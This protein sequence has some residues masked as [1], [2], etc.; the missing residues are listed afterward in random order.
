MKQTKI[1]EYTF[2]YI[3]DLYF[4]DLCK[5]LN[6]YTSN[7]EVIEDIVQDLFV[8]LWENREN[9]SIFHIKTYLFTSVRNKMLNLLRDS[10][11]FE[12][13]LEEH[14]IDLNQPD[15]EQSGFNEELY[16]LTRE[17]IDT[18]PLKCKELFLLSKKENK[19][20]KQIAEE[21]QIS[22]KTVENQMGIAYKKIREYVSEKVA[23]S[24][25]L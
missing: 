7:V 24:I 3:Y 25:L 16:L 20:Y 22:V 19:T 21:K 23:L 8:S 4:N 15:E 9:V 13:L 14:H 2:R 18:L 12:I 5:S 17:A 11:K 6:Y 1:D 10:R